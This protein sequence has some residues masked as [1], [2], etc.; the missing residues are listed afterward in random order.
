VIVEPKFCERCG[1]Q[2][3]REQGSGVTDCQEC[4]ERAKRH[5]DRQK[6][7]ETRAITLD[8]RREINRTDFANRRQREAWE[9]LRSEKVQ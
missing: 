5:A 1:K 2:F 8:A 9:R 7:P 4:S 3:F 6:H